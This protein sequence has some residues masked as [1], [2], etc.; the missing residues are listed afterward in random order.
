MRGI[1]SLLAGPL[2]RGMDYRF[3]GNGA[4][5]YGDGADEKAT[6]T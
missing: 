1:T 3:R 5:G 2:G 4:G 6:T